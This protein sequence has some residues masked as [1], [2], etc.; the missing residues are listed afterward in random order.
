MEGTKL[1]TMDKQQQPF[2]NSLTF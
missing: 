1:W 2:R